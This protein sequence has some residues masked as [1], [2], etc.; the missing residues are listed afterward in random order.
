MILGQI[1]TLPWDGIDV[2]G[3]NSSCRQPKALKESRPEMLESLSAMQECFLPPK[4]SAFSRKC[5]PG[6]WGKGHSQAWA[7]LRAKNNVAKSLNTFFA[8]LGN[9]KEPLSFFTEAV[10]GAPTT[11]A[12]TSHH[13]LTDCAYQVP[14]LGMHY[15]GY[16][17]P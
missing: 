15:A 10:L 6:V 9:L 17:G 1:S 8:D 5:S 13:S 7:R 2:G 11:Q 16:R 12:A 3:R 14:L 4:K